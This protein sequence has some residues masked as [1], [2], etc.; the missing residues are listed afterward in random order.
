S[1]ENSS[2]WIRVS[3]AWAGK[4]W[5]SMQIP[6]IGQEV[7]VSFLEGDPDRPIM[8]GRGDNAEQE[9]R[10]ELLGN[11]TQSG[12]KSRSSKVGTRANFNEIPMEHKKGAETMIIHAEKNQDIGA[13][14][15]DTQWVGHVRT[16]TIEHD[17][18]VHVKHDRTETVD[19]HETITIGVDRT[20]KVG[21]N[22]KISIGANR[23]EDVGSNETISIGVDRTEKV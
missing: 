2:C 9:V 22:E 8:T 19:N 18:T 20:E 4:K 14:N 5:G 1:N 13:E 3:Q 10:S 21:N 7:I 17:E 6:R 16:K 11:A 15:D 23:T 12:R